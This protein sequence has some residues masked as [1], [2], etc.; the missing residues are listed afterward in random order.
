MRCC[1]SVFV[2]FACLSAKAQ[3]NDSTHTADELHNIK[4]ATTLSLI[5]G[6]GQ[7]YN[8]KYWKAPVFWTGIGGGVY[9][10]GTL[11]AQFKS[12]ENVLQ[13]I[14]DNPSYSTRAELVTAAPEIF[15]AV[16]SFYQTSTDGVAQEAIGYME[17]IRAQREYTLFGI[18]GI[19]LLGILDANIDAH[20]H[21]FDV[22][23][24]LSIRPQFTQKQY[25]AGNTSFISAPG[26]S[27]KL[28]LP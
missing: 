19:Y 16:P 4:L 25:F 3:H 10:Y 7:I 24:D 5:P 20:L 11:T 27:L 15:E 22:S 23:D 21:D 6:G 2:L 8:G 18:I 12:Y 14:I 1:L 28:S 13:F 9:Y 26:L 17:Q